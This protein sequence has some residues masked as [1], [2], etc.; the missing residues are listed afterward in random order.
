MLRQGNNTHDPKT[1][2]NSIWVLVFIF[3]LVVFCSM[4]AL[5]AFD[6]P[7]S[8]LVKIE[9]FGKCDLYEFR[10]HG[11]INYVARCNDGSKVATTDSN[12]NVV[13]TIP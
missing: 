3:I 8:G 9:S 7:D 12:G 4:G 13:V 1:D 6:K 11:R 2:H 5:G 10:R